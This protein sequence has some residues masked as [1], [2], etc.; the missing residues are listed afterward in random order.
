MQSFG[1]FC[2]PR[3]GGQAGGGKGDGAGGNSRSAHS[4]VLL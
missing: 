3:P 1:T 4:P 2:S